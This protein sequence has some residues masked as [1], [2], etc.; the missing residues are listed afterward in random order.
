MAQNGYITQDEAVE[1]KKQTL[2][3]NPRVAFPNAANANYFTE[4]VRR[5][6]SERYGETKLYEGGLSV[7]ATLDPKMQSW[8]R[9]ALVDGLVRYDQGRGWRGAERQVD[10]VGRDWGLAVSEMPSLG[11]IAPWRLAVVLSTSGGVAQIGLQP[12][13]EASGAVSR[14]ARPARSRR[15]A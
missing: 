1:A 4:E 11:D 10:L 2:G 6:I 13:R 7:R 5:E 3:V 12:R 9:K 8:A 15:K 14:T